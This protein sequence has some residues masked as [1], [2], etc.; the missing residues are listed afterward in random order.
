MVELSRSQVRPVFLLEDNKPHP[1]IELHALRWIGQR[2]RS[3]KG[4]WG[5]GARCRAQHGGGGGDTSHTSS[6]LLLAAAAASQISPPETFISSIATPTLVLLPAFQRTDLSSLKRI[7]H[8]SLSS[9]F[10]RGLNLLGFRQ[11]MRCDA[12]PWFWSVVGRLQPPA[13]VYVYAQLCKTYA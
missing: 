12:N 3:I 5:M 6:V 1:L 2:T 11:G 7:M 9:N 8:V 13:V 10:D 4:G